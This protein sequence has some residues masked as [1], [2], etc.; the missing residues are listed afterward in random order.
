MATVTIISYTGKPFA[1]RIDA[2]RIMAEKLEY[3]NS[4]EA[5]I[6]GIP[7]GGIIVGAEVARILGS[8]FD[9]VLTRK[10]GSP[11]NPELAIGAVSENGD[12]IINKILAFESGADKEY[13]QEEKTRQLAEISR[14]NKI[15][16]RL[17][18]RLPLKGKI[19][20]I[21][22]D[23]VA[24]GATMQSALMAARR[25][26]PKSIIAAFPVGTRDSIAKL[27][28]YA[29]EIICLRL[30]DYFAAVGQFYLEFPQ[31]S[32]EE[33]IKILSNYN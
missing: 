32:D 29:D 27:S 23:G 8:E 10:L 33:I 1:N 13:I 20:V 28:E 12:V 22:D 21:I 7:R 15:Y 19:A 26:E 4:K 18:P 3:L 24:T 5:V 25:E 31:V 2:G 17:R 9:I 14:R 30:P 16:R 6:L 11:G